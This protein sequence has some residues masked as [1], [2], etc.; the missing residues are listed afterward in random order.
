[1][2]KPRINKALSVNRAA[3]KIVPEELLFGGGSS[4]A[5]EGVAPTKGKGVRSMSEIR[6]LLFNGTEPGRDFDLADLPKLATDDKSMAWV[7]MSGYADSDLKKL[8][9]LLDLHPISVEAALAPWQRPQVNTFPEYFYLSVTL[10][11]PKG[12]FAV[13]IG[14]LDLFVGKNYMLTVHKNEVPFLTEI[15]DR[16]HQSPDLVRLHTAY[17]L[18]IILDEMLDF[19]QKLFEDLEDSVEEI[20]ETALRVNNDSFLADVLRLKRH[21]F[22]VGRLAEQH[23]LVFS[24]FTRP[25]FEFISGPEVEPYFRDLH[26]RLDQIVERLFAARDSVTSAFQI[27]VS[28]MSHQTNQV[29]KLLAVV[30]TVLLPATLIVGFFGTSFPQFAFL[31]SLGAF[32]FMV[33]LLVIVP[34]T[35]MIAFRYRKFF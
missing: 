17:L 35:V 29:M 33:A 27:Y 21:V 14:E 25:D 4:A 32:V 7:D 9:E 18:Y 28:Q 34:S 16:V 1:V 31:H 24:A 8:A 11:A 12:K 6:T 23:R 20:E 5:K 19:Y 26:Q 2:A 13:D 3:K 22:L 10:I 15:A 30:S